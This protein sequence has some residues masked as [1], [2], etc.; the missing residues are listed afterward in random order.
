[1][2]GS[3]PVL[4]LALFA[5]LTPAP[6]VNAADAPRPNIVFI[7]TDDQRWDAMGCAGHPFLKTP[8]MDRLAREGAM[9]TNAFV[10]TPL[11]SPSRSSFLTGQYVHTTGVKANGPAMNPIGHQLMTF[12]RLLKDAGYES[13][14]VGKWHM[15]NDDSPR[16]GFDRWV[17]FKGQGRYVDPELNVD[18]ETEQKQGYVTD[19]V[20]DYA[21]DF[22]NRAHAKPFVL[23]VGHKAVHGPFTPA[24]RHNALYES[25]PIVRRPSVKDELSGK[26]VLS[27]ELAGVK[28][29]QRIKPDGPSD[30]AP[31]NQ[32]RCLVSVDEGLGRILDA[33]DEKKLADDTI[34]IFTSDNGF[35]WG[36]HRLADKRAAYEESIRVP[37]L[38]R[39][40]KLIKPGTK[41]IEMAL[42]I[43]IAPTV[44]QLA[45]AS[46]PKNVHGQSLVGVFE[47]KAEMWRRVAL[48]EYFQEQN[49]PR[50]PTWQA[51]RTDRW[52][53][54]H[55][56]DVADADE[57]YD[58]RDDPYEMKN[59]IAD[60]GAADQLIS[61]KT[62]LAEQL[63]ETK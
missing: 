24:E 32:L 47:G 22:I 7:I 56:P 2:R 6:R 1:M 5:F 46:I 49:F 53:Y 12:P 60:A 39:Y 36:E 54:I 21:V 29:D 10:T 41:P 38:M 58:L 11:C 20:S 25:E 26:P 27:R 48:F 37:L 28:N 14:Y 40:P 31:R 59:L 52:K 57:L 13:A 19:I 63:H 3:F 50:V 30:V 18:G 33:L 55:Y 43:D 4:V 35:F 16:P 8:N 51:L 23:Y 9:F 61:M 15:G 42:N 44:L 62:A 17:S 34:V 45:G